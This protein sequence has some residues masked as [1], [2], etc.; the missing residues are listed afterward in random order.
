MKIWPFSRNDAQD[1]ERRD[2]SY[3]DTLIATITA[4]ASGNSTALP[5]A[6]AALEACA[7]LVG[8]AFASADVEAPENIRHAL[9][10][11]MMAL[12]GRALIVRGE[13]VAYIETSTGGLELWPAASH[14][15]KGPPSGWRYEVTIGGPDR[16]LTYDDVPGEGVVHI[17]FERDAESPWRGVGPLQAAHLAGRLSAETMKALADESS[18]P[19]GS[20]LPLPV[21]GQDSTV[22]R[23]KADIKTLNGHIATVQG[24]DWDNP[25]TGGD[26]D[27]QT[28]RL[29]ADPPE[30]L[31]QLAEVST[32]E[33]FAACGV[34]PA[35]LMSSQGTA[36]REAYR[37]F[38]FSL[39]APLGRIVAHELSAKLEAEISL[40]WSELRAADIASRARAF[41]SMVG[42]GME[43]AKAA[44]LSGLMMEE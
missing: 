7:G 11:S 6:T 14:N 1:L 16:M 17:M 10:P 3:T 12:I 42:S 27:W 9:T 33:V 32:R 8:R 34:N 24:G 26:A 15:V 37:Q 19:R 44:A 29:G 30:S 20:L 28:K 4:N 18:G 39:V 38:L 5:T 13:I 43:L 36:G 25:G 2:S 40:D 21:D 31:V 23:L 22:E 41:Q 35:V